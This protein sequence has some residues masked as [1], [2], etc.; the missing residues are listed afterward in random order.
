MATV[1]STENVAEAL[2]T[3]LTITDTNTT[4][5][6]PLSSSSSLPLT[7]PYLQVTDD[8]HVDHAIDVDAEFPHLKKINDALYVFVL[9]HSNLMIFFWYLRKKQ[10]L[11]KIVIFILMKHT[12]EYLYI[13]KDQ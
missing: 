12:I 9:F 1:D 10:E 7:N 2:E 13:T 4:A 6:S 8:H 3:Q 5:T 11:I